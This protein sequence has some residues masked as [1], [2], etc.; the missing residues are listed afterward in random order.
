MKR[1]DFMK[2]SLGAVGAMGAG[3][4]LSGLRA[5]VVHASSHVQVSPTLVNIMLLGGADFRYMLVPAPGSDYAQKFW[6]ARQALYRNIAANRDR[7]AT[8]QNV[9]DDLYL[10]T[11]FQGQTFGIHKNAAWLKQ[12]FDA[13]NVAIV[14]NV[15]GSVN[16][17]HDHSQ[18]IVNAGDSNAGRLSTDRD[19]WGGR[20]AYAMSDSRAVA[21]T[22]NVSVFCKGTDASNRNARVVHVSDSRNFVLATGTGGERQARRVMGRAL[23][24]YY[25]AK[26]QAAAATNNEGPFNRFLQHEQALRRFGDA[27]E[28]YLNSVA[29]Q[30]P[31]PLRALYDRSMGAS[32]LSSRHFGKQCANLYDSLLAAHIFNMR[33]ASMSYSGW[34]TH[35][36][37]KPRFE[38]N[39]LDL[40]GVDQGLHVLTNELES[41]PG[42]NDNLVYTFNTDFGRQLRANGSNGT[43]HG[44]GNY[45]ILLGRALQ[46]GVY[47]EMFP[48]SEITD[49]GQGIRY[50]KQGADIAGRTAFELVLSRVCDWVAPGSGAQVFNLSADLPLEQGVDLSKLFA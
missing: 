8:Y 41:F 6:E 34:D 18:L 38:R 27:F 9:W 28:S 49:S 36:N 11:T 24:S 7:Y 43:D 20:L 5:P 39:I 10:P 17:R 15:Q 26:G 35:A 33:V 29:P 23:K 3:L 47:G 22:H 42:V 45:L 31:Q 4:G 32:N 46:G 2:Q 48:Q 1:R 50:D 30:Q 40:F 37:Q 19:G 13:G 12:Q 14:A 44:R 25:Q 21:L 16:R